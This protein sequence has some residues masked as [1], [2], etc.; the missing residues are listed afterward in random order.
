[1]FAES[2]Y[3]PENEEGDM[4][5]DFHGHL[6][7]LKA[8]FQKGQLSL[9]LGA[10]VSKPNGLPGW[11]ELVQALYFSTLNDESFIHEMKP[12]PNY[13]F[14]LAEWVL[15][16]KN[17]PLDIIIRK[18]RQWYE[19]K[20]FIGMLRT[21]L[22]AGFGRQDTRGLPQ[23]LVQQNHTLKAIVDCCGRSVPGVKGLRSIVTYNYDNVVELALTPHG[24]MR[25]FQ[26]IYR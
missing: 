25:R 4:A 26:S 1:I 13:L 14:A 12:Y 20:D 16:Q 7:R 17:E 11:E 5:V 9:Y 3:P 15:R 6:P 8:A 22:Y 18:L 23:Y 10:G 19:G 21:T 24:G 2:T